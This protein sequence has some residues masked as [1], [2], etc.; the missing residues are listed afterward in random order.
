MGLSGNGFDDLTAAPMEWH[1]Y[2]QPFA[3]RPPRA[4]V[5]ISKLSVNR[6][7]WT[8]RAKCIEIK[9]TWRMR[10]LSF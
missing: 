5:G 10:T 3:K 9:A 6:P 8:Y 1:P 2:L 4:G 7:V